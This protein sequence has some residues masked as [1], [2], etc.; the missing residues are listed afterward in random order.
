MTADFGKVKIVGNMVSVDILMRRPKTLGQR[1]SAR[2]K[3]MLLTQVDLFLVYFRNTRGL[4]DYF[5]IEP[6]RIGYVPFKVN[7]WENGLAEQPKPVTTS[8]YAICA[9][10][11]LRDIQTFVDAV[12]ISGVPGVLLTPGRELMKRHGTELSI[13]NPPPNL[14]VVVHD[15]GKEAT[16]LKWIRESS[17]VVIPRFLHDITSTGISTYLCAMAMERCV[18][19]SKGPGA[20]DILTNGQAVLVDP[21]SSHQL[22]GA[23]NTLWKDDEL[24]SRI[25]R[26]GRKYVEGLKGE[27]RLLRDVLQLAL[28]DCG[29]S[30]I[31]RASSD[32][33]E[34]LG[35]EVLRSSTHEELPVSHCR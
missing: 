31:A 19:L 33:K 22:A 34:R 28:A 3:R 10:Q 5:G 24:R 12:R 14:R 21:E 13:A 4:S 11:T 25:A 35:S 32:G 1:C 30:Q 7:S 17:V 29:C 6:S 23:L 9:G 2:I 27:D 26:K 20:D 16:F 18:I 8:S 15:D